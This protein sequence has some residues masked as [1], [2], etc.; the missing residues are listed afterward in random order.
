ML[1]INRQNCF[2]LLLILLLSDMALMIHVTTHIPVDQPSCEFCA[3][4]GNPAH[5]TP[6]ASIELLPPAAHEIS[7][8][9]ADTVV[10]VA[11]PISYRERAP[12]TDV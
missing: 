11:E 8:G 7:T 12:P 5:A 2:A 10:R 3:G 1:L 4:H 6:P 9:Y